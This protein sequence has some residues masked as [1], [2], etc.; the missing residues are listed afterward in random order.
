MEQKDQEKQQDMIRIILNGSIL[1]WIHVNFYGEYDFTATDQNSS[2]F[3]MEKI[4]K[5]EVG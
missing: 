1:T 4:K 2:N 5:F 3:N